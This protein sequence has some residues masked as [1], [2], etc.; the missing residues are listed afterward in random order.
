MHRVRIPLPE[1]QKRKTGKVGPKSRRLIQEYQ[2]VPCG[3]TFL[4]KG[5]ARGY[6]HSTESGFRD[7]D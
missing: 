1:V 2:R 4:S 6:S 3:H 7:T 5:R